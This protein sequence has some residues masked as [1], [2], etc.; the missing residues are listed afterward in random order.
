[1]VFFDW[2]GGLRIANQGT[3]P[4]RSPTKPHPPSRLNLGYFKGSVASKH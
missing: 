1:M 2:M 4:A 3:K